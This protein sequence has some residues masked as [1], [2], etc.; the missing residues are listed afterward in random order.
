M[1]RARLEE[2]KRSQVAVTAPPKSSISTP[3]TQDQKVIGCRNIRGTW[4]WHLGLTDVVFEPNGTARHP[5]SGSIGRWTCVGTTGSIVWADRTDRMTVSQ[6][7]RS[8][9]VVSPW[10][11]GISFT[12]TRRN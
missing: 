5:A 10:G 12:S 9:F 2:L 11:G 4:T 3:T 8:I 7:G 6:D 1:A